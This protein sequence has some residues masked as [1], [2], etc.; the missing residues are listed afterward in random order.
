M[1]SWDFE[2]VRS[3]GLELGRGQLYQTLEE[4]AGLGDSC[5]L[6]LAAKQIWSLASLAQILVWFYLFRTR[7][8]SFIYCVLASQ[9]CSSGLLT[10]K[11][12][13]AL[14]F[15]LQLRNKQKGARERML[16]QEEAAPEK[17]TFSQCG[18]IPGTGL[19]E[20]GW[21]PRQDYYCSEEAPDQKQGGE[22]GKGLLGL[23]FHTVVHF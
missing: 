23:H 15:Y 17:L 22:D 10:L 21:R 5:L 6:F 20:C 14:L 16:G 3:Y 7:S 11:C 4:G 19:E 12:G 2:H 8:Y 9:L 1:C 13:V 18:S